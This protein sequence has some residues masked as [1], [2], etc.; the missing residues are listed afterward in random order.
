[1]A[2]KALSYLERK[3]TDHKLA[4]QPQKWLELAKKRTKLPELLHFL[5]WQ[6]TNI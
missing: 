2:K 1:M 3:F 5:L 6:G 4:H